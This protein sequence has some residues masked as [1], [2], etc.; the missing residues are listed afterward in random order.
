[1]SA[2]EPTRG[3]HPQRVR[4]RSSLASCARMPNCPKEV[5]TK[6]NKF[7]VPT[8]VKDQSDTKPAK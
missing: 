4:F 2:P 7:L 8:I 1:M 5:P 3:A 6:C